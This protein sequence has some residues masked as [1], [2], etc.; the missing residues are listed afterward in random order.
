MADVQIRFRADT[1]AAERET[2]RLSNEIKRLNTQLD[3][4]GRAATQAGGLVDQFGNPLRESATDAQKLTRAISVTNDELKQIST[5][6]L[7]SSDALDKIGDEARQTT[8]QLTQLNQSMTQ[9]SIGD[10]FLPTIVDA[11][12]AL[13]DS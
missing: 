12:Q 1:K 7:R 4:T 5:T 6:S 2:Q 13:A 10:L 9:A 3:S 8:L 11:A